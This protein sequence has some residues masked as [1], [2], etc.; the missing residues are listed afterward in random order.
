MQPTAYNHISQSQ[1]LAPHIDI[2]PND[3]AIPRTM[4]D[5]MLVKPDNKVNL[6]TLP[7]E[8]RLHIYHW[9]HLMCPVRHAQLAPWYPTPVH[10]QYILKPVE[11]EASSENATSKQTDQGLLSSHRPLS[12]L[13][14]YL[15]QTC[16]QIYREAR[17]VPFE[18]NEFVFVNWF[19][20]GLW[21][22]RAFTRSLT[23]WQ[24]A[25][26]RYVRLEVLARDVVVGGAG[27]E[28]WRTLCREWSP[29]VRGLRMKMVLGASTSVVTGP[30]YGGGVE[31]RAEAAR[32]WVGE[33]LVFMTRLERIE[34]EVVA[35]EMSDW[36]KVTW[37]ETLQKELREG[38][39]DRAVV[40]CTEKVQEKMEWIKTDVGWK[41]REIEAEAAA[42]ST[43]ENSAVVPTKQ[44]Q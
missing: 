30:A 16:H 39:L 18:Q 11:P 35:R 20:S 15:L 12:G 24:R 21:A 41:N 26:L 5:L 32:Q 27:R 29:G 7:L 13:P 28:E 4:P 42:D 34:M 37:C 14:T 25:A 38:G 17:L 9:L 36:D 8:I 3:E 19:A 1:S 23:Q 44:R 31:R 40:V 6:L 43:T 33:G 22:A 10:C 2:L